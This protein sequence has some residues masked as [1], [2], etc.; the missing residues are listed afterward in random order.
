MAKKPSKLLVVMPCYNEEEILPATADRM[1]KLLEEMVKDGLVAAD[2]RVCLVNDGSKDQTWEVIK[3][4][5][6][7]KKYFTALTL[8]RNFGQQAAILAGLFDNEADLYVTIDADLQDDPEIIKEMLAEA[9]KGC[10]IVYGVRDNRDSDGFFKKYTALGFYKLMQLL[11]VKTVY[12]HA[13]FRLMSRRAVEALRQFPERNLFIRAMV[14]LV[15][16]RSS[17]VYCKRLPRL[18]GETKYPLNKLLA[19]AWDGVSSF[20][21]VPLRLVTFTGFAMC[22]LSVLFLG[23]MFYWWAV[24]KT[25]H[26]WFSLV[27]IIT[28]FSGVQL[29]SLGIIGEYVAKIFIEVKRRPLYIVNERLDRRK[30]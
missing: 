10:D 6:G 30:S 11:G 4:I 15:G 19:L 8:S 20:S 12:N 9:E 7:E 2:S 17:Q 24:G 27:T 1:E 21:I 18:A 28:I 16:F 5:C 29:L 26:G 23:L 22:L 14:P 25:V 13:E 3:K